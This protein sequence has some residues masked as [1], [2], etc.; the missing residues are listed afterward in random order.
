MT[1]Y[2][3]VPFN[4]DIEDQFF[5]FCKE[6][7]LQND[8]AAINMWADNWQ[9]QPHTLPYILINS[10]RYSKPNGEFFL[11]I[12]NLD[13]VGC[14]GIYISEFNSAVALAGCRTWINTEHRNKS[15][16]RELILPA[17]KQWAKSHN[18]NAVGLTFN[19]YN[20]NLI[21]AWKRKR[22][23]ESRS[24]RQP[25]HL[26][27]NNFNEVEFPVIIQYTKQWIIYETLNKD[28]VFDWNCI[29]A[30]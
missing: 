13:I 15:L 19:E 2:Q 28:F 16:P 1:D 27:Y 9:D 23:G 29:K 24:S 12:Y 18:A 6:A 14:S 10:N 3:L 26:F 17:Q 7:S 8:P 25:H 11:V 20:K 21:N 4:K 5:K 22:L 30:P